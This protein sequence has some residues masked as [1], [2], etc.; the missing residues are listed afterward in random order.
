M[1][2]NKNDDLG[3]LEKLAIL[4]DSVQSLY[5]GNAYIV[6]ELEKDEYTSTISHFREIDRHH[7][8]F[9]IQISGTN[10]FFLK[11]EEDSEIKS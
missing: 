11:K 3:I 6:F 1:E 8:K 7:D 4:A 5:K 2:K 10:F 9:N